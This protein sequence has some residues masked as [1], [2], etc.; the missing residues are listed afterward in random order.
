ME[1]GGWNTR[2]VLECGGPPPLLK[3]S[4]DSAIQSARGLA[5][6]KTWRMI[7]AW[8]LLLGFSLQPSAFSLRALGQTYTIDWNKI[9]GGGGTSTG[10]TYQVSGTIGQPDAS[11]AMSGGNYSLTGGFWAAYAVQTP[12]APYLSVLRTSTN[13][14]CVWWPVTDPGWQLEATA[15]LVNTGST[16]SPCSYVTNGVNCVFIESPPAG[17]RFYRLQKP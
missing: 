12:G 2:S 8:L 16:W 6:S 15:S 1:A 4:Q 10:S 11:G 3:R 7:G 17:N 5:Q 9:S 14:I 13:T